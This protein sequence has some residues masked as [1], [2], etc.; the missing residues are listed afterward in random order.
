MRAYITASDITV[1][2]VGLLH[3]HVAWLETTYQPYLQGSDK[4]VAWHLGSADRNTRFGA[5]LLVDKLH[6]LGGLRR[7]S[8]I[9]LHHRG[10]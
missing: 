3:Y 1:K 10:A 4:Q 8:N 5:N 6:H 9:L 7:N 2:K